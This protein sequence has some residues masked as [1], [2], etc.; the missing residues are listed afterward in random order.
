MSY[1]QNELLWQQ[2]R[3]RLT[4]THEKLEE[5]SRTEE[6]DIKRAALRGL[7][8][9]GYLLTNLMYCR[10]HQ[11]QPAALEAAKLAVVEREIENHEIG[12]DSI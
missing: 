11:N 4:R 9:Q 8:Q 6:E 3:H 12:T 10:P 1:E 5:K 7:Y 2:L